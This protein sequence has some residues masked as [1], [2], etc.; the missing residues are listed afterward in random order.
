MEVNIRELSYSCTVGDKENEEE[1]DQ[2]DESHIEGMNFIRDEVKFFD[3][4]K[5]IEEGNDPMP[6]WRRS[7]RSIFSF[8]SYLEKRLL[9]FKG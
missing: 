6:I 1:V 8:M 9:K 7:R 5:G 4:C 2:D 3:G